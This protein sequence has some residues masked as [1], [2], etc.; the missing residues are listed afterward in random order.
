MVL[1]TICLTREIVGSGVSIKI[2]IGE[3][4]RKSYARKRKSSLSPFLYKE[5]E[6][7]D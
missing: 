1:F 3:D 6:D 5:E 7:N 4:I 2:N